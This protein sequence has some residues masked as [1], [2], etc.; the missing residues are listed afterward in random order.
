MC[1]CAHACASVCASVC[2]CV[3]SVKKSDRQ[4]V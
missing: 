1:V 4:A 3:H 2:E